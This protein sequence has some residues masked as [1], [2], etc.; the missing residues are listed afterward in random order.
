MSGNGVIGRFA[1][2]A[3]VAAGGLALANCSGGLSSKLDPRYGVSA[4]A[5]VVEPGQ[6]VP[7]GGGV[8]RVGKPYVV[9]GRVYVPEADPHYSAVG[10]ASWYGDDFHG[11]YTANGEI[12]DENSISAAHPTL[13]LPSYVRVTNLA[14][15]K[16]I[17]VRVNDRG[18]Y[19]KGRLI[20]L[21]VK[22][23]QL[24]GFYGHGIAKVKVDYVGKAPLAGSDDRKL[25]A[26]LRDG[27][28]PRHDKG[29]EV[30]VAA[31]GGNFAPYFDKRPM[32]QAP[33]R[34]VP[35][36]PERPYAGDDEPQVAEAAESPPPNFDQRFPR[37][38]RAALDP[39]AVEQPGRMASPVSAYAPVRYD[40]SAGFMSGRGLY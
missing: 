7:K 34:N 1:R 19:A 5:R 21:S 23:A 9:A 6:P 17:I 2:L 37:I 3:A 27:D 18:P 4:S 14:N 40:A 36:P 20:D 32:A 12:F 33:T 16:S 22:T 24:L 13:P 15:R 30:Q 29:R 31:A 8:Y 11:R 38:E 26:T 35:T 25:V 39:P 28:T 10:L